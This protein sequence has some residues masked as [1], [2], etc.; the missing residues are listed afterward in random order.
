VNTS[1]RP[2]SESNTQ[3]ES[4]T[5]TGR[6]WPFMIV[7]LLLLNVA[8]CATTVTLSLRNPAAVEPDYYARGMNWDENRATTQTPS[9]TDGAGTTTDQD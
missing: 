3:A 1:T 5:H 6:K 8:V 9:E 2:S 4:P 7:G